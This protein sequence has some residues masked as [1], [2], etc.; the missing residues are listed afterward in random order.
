MHNQNSSKENQE[1]IFN[2]IGL[3]V[4]SPEEILEWSHGEVKKPETINYRTQ[5]PERDG[6]FCEKIFGPTKNW[7]CYCGKYKRIRYKGV[8]CEKCGVEVTRSQVR[9]ER[10]GHIKLAVPV[11]HIW[12]LRST[13]SRIGLLLDLPIKALEQ[14]VYFASYIVS[15][16]DLAEK[17]DALKLLQG[18]FKSIKKQLQEEFKRKL[19][20]A[21]NIENASARKKEE[22][23]LENEYTKKLEDLDFNHSSTKEALEKLKI[24]QVYSELEYRDMSMKFGHIFKAGTGAETIRNIISNLDLEKLSDE[25]K[26]KAKK[27]SGQKHKKFVK[28]IKLIG[29]LLKA[30]IK[31]E[32]FI[33]TVLPVIPPDLRP[34]VQLDGGRFAA[35]DLNDL[36]RRVINRNNRLKRLM[37]IGAPEVICRNEKRMLQEAIDTLLNNS[38]RQGRTA[39]NA[40]EK[41]KLRSLSDMLK[42]KQGRFRQNLLGKRVDYSGRS[43]IVVGPNL[44]LDECGIP[45]LM[46]VELFKPFIIGRLIRDGFAH[47]IKMAEKL[48]QNSKKEVWDILED[49]TNNYNVL[50]NRAPTLHRLGIQA[51]RPKLIEGKAI[52]IH[53]LVCAA[54]NADFDGDQMAIH[55]PLSASAQKESREIMLSAKNMLKPATGLPIITPAQDIVLGCHYLTKMTE[56]KKGEGMIFGTKEEAMFAYQSDLVHLQSPIKYRVDGE[57]IDTTVGRIIFNNCLPQGMKFLNKA[58]NKSAISKLVSESFKNYGEKATAIL[59]DNLK[60]TGYKYATTS[61]ISISQADMS[62]PDIKKQRIEEASELVRQIN[63]F[64]WKGLITDDERYLHTIKVWSSAKTDITNAMINS[65]DSD[66]NIYYMIDS[67]ARGNWGQVTQMAGMKGLVAN[68]AGKTI[69]LP[70]KS[71]L[72]EGFTILEYFVA[73][74]GGRKGK[75]DTALNTAE[76]GYL[77]RRLV[78]ACQDLVIR[79]LDCGSTQYHTISRYNDGESEKFESKIYG[80]TLGEDVVDRQTGEI[81]EKAGNI[82]ETETIELFNKHEIKEVKLRSVMTCNT[83]NGICGACYGKDLGTNKPVDLGVAVGIIAAQSIGEPGT[84]LTMRTFHSGGVAQEGGDITQGLTR[85]E[86]LFEARTPKSPAIIAEIGGKSKVKQ[87][88]K[89]NEVEITSLDAI[90]TKYE[91]IG[92]MQATVKEGAIVKPKMTIARSDEQKTSLKA[93]TEGKV[94][95]IT[96]EHIVIKSSGPVSKTYIVPAGRTITIKSGEMI[97][98]GQAITNGHLD[99]KQLMPHSGVYAVGKYL[100]TE[101]QKIYESQGQ[102]INDKHVEIIA[103]QMLSK[104]RIID[105]G[106]SEYLPGEVVDIIT[107]NKANAKLIEE[108]KAKATGERLLMGLSRISLS[109]NSWLSAASFQETIRVLVEASTTN[110]IDKLEG[111][112]ENVIIGKLI[113]AGE[114]YRKRNQADLENMIAGR[115]HIVEIEEMPEEEIKAYQERTPLI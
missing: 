22:V 37:S 42:G 77:T 11:A 6:L 23:D 71:N 34:M 32:W 95:E 5:K 45:K 4:A 39:F 29:H 109:T 17:E 115:K 96:G 46:A 47:N 101:V 90:E 76:A 72:K 92:D 114:T 36:Y 99:L 58:M 87:K 73:T 13:P 8:V 21:E 67:G 103:K 66:N 107:Y 14:V 18:E 3:S 15:E 43:V 10:M 63:N 53:P 41:R 113:P 84:Q 27:A 85:V 60:A 62:I 20:D 104:V 40:G 55:V 24:G 89:I 98:K 26:E 68:P 93:I 69:E 28:R 106:D 49:I 52:Q 79:E 111:L 83:E 57:I 35:S 65:V 30:G 75:S 100:V 54:Y 44:K 33:M 48:I 9:R 74:H 110:K 88:G 2:S 78:D 25:L 80:R 82:I 19:L 56:G 81:L 59:A 7:E 38:T 108:G 1:Q 102:S 51:F 91:L 64:F 105:G 31:P 94:K 97:E 16:V 12:Y 112:K 50:L 70:I 86:E 61:G